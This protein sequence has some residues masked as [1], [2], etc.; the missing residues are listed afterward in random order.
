MKNILFIR[1]AKSGWENYQNDKNRSLTS[2]G[3]LDAAKMAHHL[4]LKGVSIELFI[5]SSADRAIETSGIFKQIYQPKNSIIIVENL[6]EPESGDFLSAIHS[7]EE[8]IN[9]VAIFSHNPGITNFVNSLTNARIDSM[10]ECGIFAMES[11]I[12]KWK[13]FSL[14]INRF[15][16][17]ASPATIAG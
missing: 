15:L 3:K 6:Y 13:D 16:F 11:S 17:F 5:S 12:N 1:H 2:A 8:N 10:P 14:E 4:M 7:I 9:A